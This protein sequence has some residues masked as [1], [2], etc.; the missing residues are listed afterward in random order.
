M[1]QNNGIQLPSGIFQLKLKGI[2]T[3]IDCQHQSFIFVSC[4]FVFNEE[5]AVFCL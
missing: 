4:D 3:T 5:A 1:K 2:V